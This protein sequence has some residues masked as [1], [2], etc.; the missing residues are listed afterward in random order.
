[1]EK[2]N[3]FFLPGKISVVLDLC[4]GSSGKGSLGSFITMQNVGKFQFV[5]NTFA[6]QASHTVIDR[7]NGSKEIVYKQ[8]N[9]NAHRHH[10]FEKMYIG[11]G[12]IIDLKAFF[13]EI[14]ITGIPHNKIG[15]SPMTAIVQDIDRLYEEG[16]YEFNGTP[17]VEEHK[18]TYAT[19]STSSGVGCTR[20]RRVLRDKNQLLAKDVP[21]LAEFICDVPKEILGRLSKGQSGL[22][23]L[24]QGFPLSNGY[25]LFGTNTTSRNV[26]VS[27]G[28]D[29]MFLPVTVVGNVCLNTR[30]FPIR[31]NSKKYID[32]VSRKF[33]TWEEVKSGNYDFQEV[34]SYSG[35]WYSDQTE[36]SWDDVRILCGADEDLTSLTTLTKLPRRVATFSK[37]NLEDAIIF[38]QTPHK[39]FISVNFANYVDWNMNER[40]DI[41]TDKFKDWLEENIY[42]VIK[43]SPEFANVEMRW[44]GTGK[45]TEDRF[46]I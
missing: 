12:A 37:K 25:G 30:T 3:N 22:L 39:I 6:P 27:A 20:A 13:K 26:T 44:I 15:I 19:G 17:A 42:S 7:S 9:S 5:C 31:I 36:L 29:D 10:E 32:I 21:E 23:E 41:V 40:T 28:L 4:P 11:Q 8:F 35:D 38:N 24:A 43:S 45:Y 1:M 34:D 18:G 2:E 14:E 16:K 33:L 46:E